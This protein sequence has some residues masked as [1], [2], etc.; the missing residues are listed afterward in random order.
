[1]R[2]G[3]DAGARGLFGAHLGRFE[4]EEGAW[5][6]MAAAAPN[7]FLLCAFEGKFYAT[8]SGIF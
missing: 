8:V 6:L 2:L 3:R 4:R 1:M 5:G 7:L